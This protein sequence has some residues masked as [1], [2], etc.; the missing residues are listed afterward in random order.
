MN[1]DAALRII[2]QHESELKALGIESLSLFGSMARGEA[3]D[4]SDVDVAVRLREGP[5]G[6][7]YFGRLDRI[8]ARLR[9]ILGRPV[10][11]VPEPARAARIQLAIERDRILAY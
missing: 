10:D 8:E 5:H 4:T 2:R 1:R 6:F 9:E 3:A 11:V 7:A